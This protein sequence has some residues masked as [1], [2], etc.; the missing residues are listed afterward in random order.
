MRRTIILISFTLLIL[1]TV[2]TVLA[3]DALVQATFSTNPVVASPG[4]DGYIQLTLKNSGSVDVQ[5]VKATLSSNDAGIVIDPSYRLVDLGGLGA[6]ESTSTLF[7]FSV[8]KTTS[9][10]LYRANFEIDYCQSSGT[11]CREINQFAIINVQSSST[12][13]LTSVEPSS[14]MPGEKTNMVFTITNK[15]DNSIYNIIFTWTSSSNTVLPLGSGNR[16]II[17]VID[18][19]SE[20][21]VSVDASATSSATPGIYPLNTYIQYSDKSGTTQNISSITGIEIGGGTDF[22][23]G[24]QESTAGST[25][26]S[27]A[28]IGINP[29]ASVAVRIPQQIG[30]SVTGVTSVF[31]GD[32]N[33]GDYTLASFQLSERNFT[34]NIPSGMQNPTQRSNITRGNITQMRNATGNLLN[35]EISYTDTNGF[36]QIIQKEISLT[37][38]SSGAQFSSAFNQR[39]SQRGGGIGTWVYIVIGIVVV[40]TIVAFLKFK[41][42]KKK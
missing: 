7:K 32:L 42:R 18:A 14:L 28:N 31:L 38:I 24:L 33:P 19:N 29:A 16:I 3:T 13:E 20:Y 22:D 39:F 10:G 8:P 5:A 34:Q 26:L 37:S 9:A 40:A 15:G 1:I 25:S 30:F 4:S 2:N 36:R 6:G 11:N 27:I 17:P 35:V 23:V 21:N 12:L 41:K